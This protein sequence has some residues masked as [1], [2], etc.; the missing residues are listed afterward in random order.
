MR[1]SRDRLVTVI[2]I[3][4]ALAIGSVIT[5]RLPKAADAGTAPFLHQAVVGQQV[6]LR[7]ALVR[8][9]GVQGSPDIK[10]QVGARYISSSHSVSGVW[11]VLT[12][13]YSPLHEPSVPSRTG[14]R[15]KTTDG[16][17]FS[18]ARLSVEPIGGMAQPG[19]TRSYTYAFEVDPAALEGAHL[20]WPASKVDANDDVADIDLGITAEMATSFAT[21]ATSVEMFASVEKVAQP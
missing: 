9:D 21:N 13:S 5:E 1:Y 19:F 17:T 7:N 10:H 4:A 8:V 14:L 2:L 12:L 6:A 11:L 20:L 18:D 15:V 16:R 3:I